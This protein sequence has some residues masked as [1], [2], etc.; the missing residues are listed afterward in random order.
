M[1]KT[2]SNT[3]FTHK[4]ATAAGGGTSSNNS[5]TVTNGAVEWNPRL[6]GY[7]LLIVFSL[8]A[9]TSI[10]FAFQNAGYTGGT[11]LVCLGI[12]LAV[13]TLIVVTDLWTS[14]TA[15]KKASSS[16]KASTTGGD[17]GESPAIFTA[18]VR[19]LDLKNATDHREKYVLLALCLCQIIAVISTTKVGGVAYQASN[20]YLSVWVNL[21]LSLRLC[22]DWL[23]EKN[24]ISFRN[25][26]HLS[27]TL[28][29]WYGLLVSSTV[30]L[31]SVLDGLSQFMVNDQ[32]R[33]AVA[34]AIVTCVLSIGIPMTIILSF[35]KLCLLCS[36]EHQIP[37]RGWWELLVSLALAILWLA[38]LLLV[39]QFG[40]FGAT[41]GGGGGLGDVTCSSD[42]P[43][44]PGSNVYYFSWISFAMAAYVVLQWKA[45]RALEMAK[46]STPT[47]NNTN[48]LPEAP[49]F[50][51]TLPV[52]EIS[53]PEQAGDCDI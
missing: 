36:R 11:S 44:F 10:T 27:G 51:N 5:A 45:E 12:T 35:Y 8:A 49:D 17:A 20:I 48:T 38:E 39:T 23:Q 42:Q 15:N 26:T 52:E 4:S 41:G 29:G 53:S 2:P 47:S 7:L 40:S 3:I 9:I 19:C 18:V 43:Y 37:V 6:I 28:R 21:I 46:T 50:S 33:L 1:P 31:G 30:V 24:E 25:L 34:V 22:D 16:T 13:C 14:N 32:T